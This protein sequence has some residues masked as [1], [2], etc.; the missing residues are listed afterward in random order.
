MD[1]L[2]PKAPAERR[3]PERDRGT[4]NR[5]DTEFVSGMWTQVCEWMKSFE[6]RYSNW[7]AGDL[8]WTSKM[9][10]WIR[11]LSYL[12]TLGRSEMVSELVYSLANIMVLFNDSILLSALRKQ[13]AQPLLKRI[14]MKALAIVETFQ[15]CLEMVAKRYLGER[16]KWAV[17]T[18][19]SFFK[20]L[21][22]AVLLFYFRS[23]LSHCQSS[24]PLDRQLLTKGTPQ[25]FVEG[26]A[27]GDAIGKA[28]V[29]T[30]TSKVV[31]S[32]HDGK[33]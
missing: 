28:W 22:R 17:I 32:I 24:Q 20:F 10:A 25:L 11:A 3:S 6:K 4:V 18:F 31:R 9:E 7:I 1:P 21:S 30:R 14:L 16:W 12:M 29:G 33:H 19:I 8:E 5:F 27:N 15:A 2:E 23:G 13:T 26:E